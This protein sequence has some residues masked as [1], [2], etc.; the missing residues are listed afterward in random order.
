MYLLDTD[1]LIYALKGHSAVIAN[2]RRYAS[3]PKALSVISYGELIYGAQNSQQIQA[4]LAK[5]HHIQEIF[6]VMD[7]TPAVMET[8]GLL[9]ART[10]ALRYD[11]R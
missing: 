11:R 1:I 3:D 8:F 5:V 4:N 6:P 10:P 9:K 7:V 2:L